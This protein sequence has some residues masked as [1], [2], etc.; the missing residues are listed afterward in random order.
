MKTNIA[1]IGWELLNLKGK[2]E[3]NQKEAQNAST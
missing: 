1:I 2:A 3:S